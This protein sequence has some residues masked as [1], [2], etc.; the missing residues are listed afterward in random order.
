L[1]GLQAMRR[2]RAA[3]T[4]MLGLPGSSYLYQGEELGLPEVI[5]IPDD[6]REDPTFHRTNGERYGRDGCRVPIPWEKD[7]PAYGFSPSG[8]SW[9]PQPDTFGDLARDQQEGVEGSTLELYKTLLR[10]RKAE[11]LGR[12]ELQWIDTDSPDVLAYQNGGITVMCN[13]GDTPF[14]L[15]HGDVLASSESERDGTLQPG[16]AVWIQST[17][18]E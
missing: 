17:A 15:P 10:L 13:F 4:F 6:K 9:L 5:E 1:R 16:H 18:T 2:G 8:Q 12:G 3:T 7:A 11:G 14:D